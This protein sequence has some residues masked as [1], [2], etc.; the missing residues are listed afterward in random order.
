MRVA[1]VGCG[2]IGFAIAKAI[3]EN[4]VCTADQL[5]VVQ[6]GEARTVFLREKLDCSISSSPNDAVSEASL[7][8]LAVKP[9]D[10]ETA[11]LQISP[12]MS[13]GQTILSV[14][15]GLTIASIRSKL[16]Q[17]GTIVRSMPNLPARIGR[18]VTPF[19]ALPE[20]TSETLARVEKVLCTFGTALRLGSES[21]ID[22]ATA[23]SGSGPAYFYL[24]IESLLDA[25]ASVGLSPSEAQILVSETISGSHELWT[26]HFDS[27]TALRDAPRSKA[28]TTEAAFKV[29]SEK[30]FKDI[31]VEAVK[32]AA[33]RADDL[34]HILS[35]GA[36]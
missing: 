35:K 33:S 16:P 5:G 10:F 11:A 12:Y 18:A 17:A 31:I 27:L 25:A 13:R 23:I 6:R 32:A 26:R 21:A 28:G 36:P 2:N 7:V 20:T 14:M 34:S 24:F 19:Y 8:I 30:Q 22:A 9:Q 15:A 1:L 29:F 4:G 3:L